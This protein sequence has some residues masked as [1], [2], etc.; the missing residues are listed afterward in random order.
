M[1][2]TDNETYCVI[3]GLGLVTAASRCHG[4]RNHRLGCS[5]RSFT[6]T[7]TMRLKQIKRPPDRSAGLEHTEHFFKKH[8]DFGVTIE[9]EGGARLG[10]IT[11][12]PYR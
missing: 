12:N 10:I 2:S 4:A 1:E 11:A 9:E 7:H 6:S 3:A 5:I 8:R